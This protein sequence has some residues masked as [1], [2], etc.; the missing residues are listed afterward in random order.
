MLV[1]AKRRVLMVNATGAQ[2]SD[3][4]YGL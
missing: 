2:S 1:A 3:A 4:A